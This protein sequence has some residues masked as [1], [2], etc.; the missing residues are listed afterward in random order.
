MGLKPYLFDSKVR[1]QTLR[2]TA[3][4]SRHVGVDWAIVTLSRGGSHG[5]RAFQSQEA[6]DHK[7]LWECPVLRFSQHFIANLILTA[8]DISMEV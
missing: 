3:A 1:L 7:V 5:S 4:L 8:K 6:D 2:D